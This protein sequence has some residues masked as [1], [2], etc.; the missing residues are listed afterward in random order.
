MVA[1]TTSWKNGYVQPMHGIATNYIPKSDIHPPTKLFLRAVSS[2]VLPLLGAKLRGGNDNVD[3]L[4][5]RM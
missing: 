1:L 2:W 5:V 4:Y 3:T